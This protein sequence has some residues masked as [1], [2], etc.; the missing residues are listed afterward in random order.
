MADTT[1]RS[2][3][4]VFFGAT[5][6]LVY[7][8]I[9]PA[10]LDDGP[11]RPA[12]RAGHRRRPIGLDARAVPGARARERRAA[13]AVDDRAFAALM[14]RLRYMRGDYADP[15][16]LRDAPQGARRRQRPLHYLAIPPSQF[17]TIVEGLGRSG[18]AT[19]APRRRREA[20]RP[21]SRIGPRA[22]R[23]AAHRVRRITQSSGSITTSARRRCS[24]LLLF[25][26]ANT[27]LEPIWNRHYIES[28]Q[29]T[30]AE[31]FGVEGRGGFYEEAG[32]IRDV[33]QNHMLQVI[34]FLAMEPPAEPSQQSMRDEQVKILKT[35]RP[36]GQPT[37]SA[38]SSAATA[39]STASRRIRR[40]RR[41]SPRGSTSTRGA[42]TAC[43]SSCAPASRWRRPRPR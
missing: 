13:W 29:I 12:R 16:T 42:G 34:G 8:K 43:R 14:G 2:D 23:H 3:A 24:N 21:R 27:F 22:Q 26:F 33:L 28:V 32:A 10:L 9:F 39:R 37:S 18:C 1:G 40:S 31:R 35:I 6:D 30:M 20:V 11:P 25:R 36:L 5:G 15:A 4:L 19:N 17:G 41:S 38:A 7:K